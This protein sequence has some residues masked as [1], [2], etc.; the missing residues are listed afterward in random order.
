MSQDREV[1]PASTV[2]LG[3]VEGDLN[4]G[5]DAIIRGEG[6]PPN[7]SVSGTVSCSG[8]CTFECSLHARNLEARGNVDIH[9]DLEVEERV[10]VRSALFGDGGLLSVEGNMRAR[11]VGVDRKLVVDKDFNAE[12]VDVR[13]SFEVKGKTAAESVDVGGRVG[14]RQITAEDTVSVGGSISTE[15]GVKASHVR[16]GRRGKVTGPIRA[17]EVL[18][19]TRAHVEDVYGGK[20]IMEGDARARNLY[21]GGI[22]IESGCRV[23]GEVK[24]TVSLE[25][26]KGVSFGKSPARVEKL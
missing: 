2:A 7:V 17:D 15:T 3:S 25:T 26:G 13:G 20:I 23:D 5:K 24:Y 11:R 22:Y 10:R 19:G 14:A 18:I 4:V 6:T 1:P 8:D 9:G 12:K 21:G 16:I